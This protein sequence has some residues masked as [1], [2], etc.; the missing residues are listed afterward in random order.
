MTD[1]TLTR[2]ATLLD[3]DV[4]AWTDGD[5]PR[6]LALDLLAAACALL[7]EVR[8]ARAILDDKGLT[9]FL[10]CGGCEELY[11]ASTGWDWRTGKTAV[12][13]VKPRPKRKPSKCDHSGPMQRWDGT[14]WVD[15][16]LKKEVPA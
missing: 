9:W 5:C 6:D 15:A 4:L 1:A 2:I 13:W 16:R 11:V 10:R 7:V 8:K 12:Y 3:T 14:A